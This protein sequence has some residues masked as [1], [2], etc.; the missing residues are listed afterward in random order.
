MLGYYFLNCIFA[1]NFLYFIILTV[2]D[3]FLQNEF[4]FHSACLT[5]LYSELQNALVFPG[6]ILGPVIG[7]WLKACPV[8][9]IATSK[10]P[11]LRSLYVLIYNKE[12]R[13]LNHA[14]TFKAPLNISQNW[15]F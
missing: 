14:T 10:S 12:V 7:K 13:V 4:S 8:G 1:Q 11:K 2:K 6:S 5:I 9:K 15:I 3:F